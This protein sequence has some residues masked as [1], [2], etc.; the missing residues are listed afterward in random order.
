LLLALDELRR[1]DC[2]EVNALPATVGRVPLTA[3]FAVPAHDLGEL[4]ARLDCKL[5]TR[6]R[7]LGQ[8]LDWAVRT[9]LFELL[10]KGGE[11]TLADASA[12]TPLNENG[13]EA[14]LGILCALGLATRKPSG[15][16]RIT[17][18]AREYFLRE[19]PFFIGDELKFRERTPHAMYLHDGP[20]LAIRLKFRLLH[21]L[22]SMRYG[23]E[24]RIANQHTR[25][26]ASCAAAV[27]TGE[28]SSSKCVVDIAGGSGTFS[29]PLALEQPQ[30]RVILAELPRALA[31][32][33]PLLE[34]HR[35]QDRVELLGLDAFQYPWKIPP[36][37]GV[38]IGNFLHGFKDA[39]CERVCREG[40]DRLERGGNL[41]I[42][43][44]LWND[45]KDG[46]LITAMWDA[47]MRST[48]V[49]RQRTAQ[50]LVGILRNVG[51][52]RIRVVPTAGAFALVTGRKPS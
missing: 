18:L 15:H 47:A 23:S 42:H 29:I 52:E 1:L 45:N 26:L 5:F 4:L 10:G 13:A 21:L 46:P 36:C 27:R 30:T 6:E 22:P 2:D 41:W 49:G 34:R 3:G 12:R 44:L 43:E 50:E 48:G 35:V 51:F 14:L 37:D 40:F 19:S 24:V 11:I 17:S 31:N 39:T 33:R 32:I 20:G 25:N 8:F 28:F 7:R 16:Y 9:G 38:F